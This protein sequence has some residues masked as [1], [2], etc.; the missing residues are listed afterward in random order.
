MAGNV[1]STYELAKEM[2]QERMKELE[3]DIFIC[4]CEYP[5]GDEFT[6]NTQG[7]MMSSGS[8]LYALKL[9]FNH[10]FKN[11]YNAAREA[12]KFTKELDTKVTI[13]RNTYEE[14]GYNKFSHF[15]LCST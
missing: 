4:L 3:C 8:Y 6:L 12:E 15:T 13:Q 7:D 1:Y 10:K 2:A 11:K 14:N 5:S 9:P